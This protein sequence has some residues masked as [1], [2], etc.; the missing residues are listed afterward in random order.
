MRKYALLVGVEDYRDQMISR[1]RF[2]RADAIALAERLRDRCGFD[3]VRLLADESGENEPLL[4]NIL[5]AL[6]DTTAEVREDDLLL[7]F[8]AGHGVEKDG[9]GYLLACDTCQAFPEHGSL[10]LELLRKNFERVCA[11]KRILLLDACRND[12][13]AG[14]ADASNCMGDVI[15]RD[16]VA[17]ARSR[18][19]AGTTTA[20][21]SA[22][23]SG[24]R[25]Y[26]WPAKKHGVFTQC[27][28]EGLDG[29]AWS[30]GKLE[31]NRLAHYAAMHVRQWS[32]ST[33]GIS[34]PQEPWYEQFGDPE[35]ILLGSG[36]ARPGRVEVLESSLHVETVPTDAAVS[37]DGQAAGTAPLKLTLLPGEYRIRAE[38]DGYRTWERRIRYDGVGDAHLR[39]EL[40]KN[41][42]LDELE[43]LR[44]EC[45]VDVS[46]C[47]GYVSLGR[48]CGEYLETVYMSRFSRWKEA[49]D[50]GIAEGMI[51]LAYCYEDGK[52]VAKDAA[53][54]VKWYRRA[55]DQG[56]ALAQSCLG[57]CYA[58][59]KGVAE[60]KAEAVKWYSKA[61][62]Q[63]NADARQR[64]GVLY[65]KGE[66]VS[67]DYLE[68]VKWFRKAA[69]QGH[70]VSQAWLGWCYQ[71]GKGVLQDKAEAAKWYRKA[72]GQG[73]ADAQYNLG[74]CYQHGEGVAEDKLEATE[75]YRKAA[76]Q[77][78]ANAQNSLGFCYQHGEGVSKDNVEA[79][80]WY[81]KAAEQGNVTACH[82]LATCYRVGEGVPQDL[83]E[84]VNWLRKAAER[85]D[86]TSQ[87][88][89][90]RCYQNAEGVPQDHVEAVKWYR[91][92][93]N[94]GNA[95]AQ[96]W[97]GDCYY[98]GE[99]VAENKEEAVKWF[100]QAADQEIASAQFW[101]AFC[102][103]YGK[104][105]AENK[106]EA[107]KWYRK[108]AEQGDAAAQYSLGFCYSFGEGVTEDK[109]EAVKW[110][111]K[112]ADQGYASAQNSLGFCYYE[113]KGVT[114]D[115][116]EAVKWFR[117]AADQGYASAQNSLGFCYDHGEG[118]AE[119][120]AEAVKWYLKAAEQ[121]HAG[122]QKSLGFAADQGYASAQHWL[123]LCYANGKGV[124]EDMTEAVKW[125]RK[126]AD[127]GNASAQKSLGFAA[128]QGHAGAQSWLGSCYANGKG[129]A[130][131]KAE[132]VKWFRKAAEQGD[133]S[134]Q[135][136]LGLAYHHGKGVAENKVEAV[137]WFRKSA[138]Q[139]HVDAQFNLGFC[140]AKGE[141]L[142]RDKAEAVK[143]FRKAA[144][145]GHAKAK[146]A[147]GQLMIANQDG[148]QP[149][150]EVPKSVGCDLCSRSVAAIIDGSKQILQGP[151]QAATCT[152]RPW[153]A[154]PRI[155][156]LFLA[157]LPEWLRNSRTQIAVV[158]VPIGLSYRER[159][160]LRNGIQHSCEGEGR[161]VRLVDAVTLGAMG[162]TFANQRHCDSMTGLVVRDLGDY[163]EAMAFK[164][165]DGLF[166][167][168]ATSFRRFVVPA[169]QESLATGI[170]ILLKDAHCEKVDLVL[171]IQDRDYVRESLIRSVLPDPSMTIHQLASEY[172]AYGGALYAQ[173]LSGERKD[174]LILPVLPH[175]ISVETGDGLS[176]KVIDRNTTYP[177]EK[178]LI[179]STS[180]DG[181]TA[182]TVLVHE[183]ERERATDNTVLGAI[184]L[185]GLPA[186]PK[187]VPQIEVT[188]DCDGRELLKVT[189]KDL[190]SGLESS[191]TLDGSCD[192]VT[193]KR[194][195][196]GEELDLLREDTAEGKDPPTTPA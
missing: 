186:A 91:K 36:G 92:A 43:R 5:M 31:F 16:I 193:V 72:A 114:E 195:P 121:G 144:A 85:E 56:D 52:G 128:D 101:L 102:Y 57:D 21:L 194:V 129:V 190:G 73:Y 116:V 55:A 152:W 6:R 41:P 119:D 99:G 28:I 124:P 59:G 26:E 48:D 103:D 134:A 168:M 79:V 172:V 157:Q 40:E 126:A 120:M 22:C 96:F 46:E 133:A 84:A 35:T 180:R 137:K 15:S 185:C 2:A 24:Q 83:S 142:G 162:Y 12:P 87:F 112:A 66:G 97:L 179:F 13:S 94:Q 82:R 61:A 33:P 50:R 27:L 75:W 109:V 183:G 30:D 170:R 141:G 188:V 173:V 63:G 182:V 53:E 64:L 49:A 74:Y 191:V 20:L 148:P 196:P 65:A 140:Y 117:K 187:G 62:E 118:V 58:H 131:N 37:V 108:A 106:P 175:S 177:T 171:I 146:R 81:R 165:A 45:G 89:L 60:D 32:A 156:G 122:A 110:Y 154:L 111:R 153:R 80:K 51:L 113:G 164:W 161:Y 68:A 69:E 136:S 47:E 38:R 166:R 34:T 95:G 86:A 39:I 158:G 42:E 160:E 147:L 184:R 163:E 19:A 29:A 192:L 54:A 104:G 70:V 151:I 90:G 3:H 139:G 132:A 1:L 9:H 189:A 181:Q 143:W 115:K 169:G 125:Y 88:F 18:L 123:G 155:D 107:V 127:Q 7:F 167:V 105:V 138:E 76:D 145:Q 71:N 44:S 67:N 135:C 11:G 159:Y 14:R 8:F 176:N 150:P 130:E 174:L 98:H 93:A 149:E 23:R 17:A 4:G 10:S 178:K 25:A 100:R 77:R 78:N